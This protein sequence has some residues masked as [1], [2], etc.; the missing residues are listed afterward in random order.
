ML[1][2]Y[3]RVGIAANPHKPAVLTA[4]RCPLADSGAPSGGFCPRSKLGQKF[5][6]QNGIEGRWLC[7]PRCA[8]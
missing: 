8:R 1:E 2:V 6:D 5:R 3:V 4:A 7:V